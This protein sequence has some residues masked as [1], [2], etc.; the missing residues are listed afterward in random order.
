MIATGIAMLIAFNAN[1]NN[2]KYTYVQ[3][4][5]LILFH[6]LSQLNWCLMIYVIL[7]IRQLTRSEDL[8]REIVSMLFIMTVYSLIRFS[9]SAINDYSVLV[10]LSDIAS[11][12]VF[13]TLLWKIK[14]NQKEK[15]SLE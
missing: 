11:S 14:S 10:T 3:L 8:K 15:E 12:L 4:V 6:W 13:V 1:P 9:Y 2:R 7:L 5:L